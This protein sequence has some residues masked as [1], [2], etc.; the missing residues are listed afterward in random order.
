MPNTIY[1]CTSSFLNIFKIFSIL[2]R[3]LKILKIS[4]TPAPCFAFGVLANRLQRH[5]R[6]LT[7][8]K[9]SRDLSNKGTGSSIRADAPWFC[10]CNGAFSMSSKYMERLG[11]MNV[12]GLS[13]KKK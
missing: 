8:T 4:T 13:S 6:L 10:D 5:A 12:M 3:T 1:Y 2:I 11:R 7:R 9:W